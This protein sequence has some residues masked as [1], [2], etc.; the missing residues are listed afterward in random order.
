M[1]GP[2]KGLEGKIVA[3]SKSGSNNYGMGDEGVTQTIDPET[4]VSVELRKNNTVL[5]VK[6][7]RIEICDNKK[8]KSRS[9]STSPLTEKLNESTLSHHTN[10]FKLLKWVIEGIYVRV[11]SKKA[12]D[13]KLYGKIVNIRNVLDSY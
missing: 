6:R 1:S 7:K 4:Y 10:N 3:V 12:A 11:V 13:G 2:H 8:E 9:R 5:Q